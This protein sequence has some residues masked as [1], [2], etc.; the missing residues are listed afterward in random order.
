MTRRTRF[1]VNEHPVI[2]A[3]WHPELNT[4]LNLTLIGPGSHKSA[5]WQCDEGHVWQAQIHSLVAGTGCP[6]CAGYV[7]RGRAMRSQQPSMRDG[8]R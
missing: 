7:P 4:E 5:F 6:Q 8:C 2:A 1:L 3:Q